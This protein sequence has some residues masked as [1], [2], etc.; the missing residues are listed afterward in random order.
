LPLAEKNYDLAIWQNLMHHMIEDRLGNPEPMLK[1][2]LSEARRVL[3]SGGEIIIIETYC[4]DFLYR[5]QGLVFPLTRLVLTGIK[6]PLVRLLSKKR[7]CELLQENGFEV[8]EQTE[9]KKDQY[10]ILLGMPVPTRWL[11]LRIFYVRARYK[12]ELG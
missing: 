6:H 5:L 4:A 11:P 2:S 10:M 8:C 12:T 1:A 7:V 9:I 3:R